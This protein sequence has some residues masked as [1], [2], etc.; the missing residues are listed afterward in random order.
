M[1]ARP[2][3]VA[4]LV[5]VPPIDIATVLLAAMQRD[6]DPAS[7]TL[8][9]RLGNEHVTGVAQTERTGVIGPGVSRLVETL[10]RP[11]QCPPVGGIQRAIDILENASSLIITALLNI[12]DGVIAARV[13]AVLVGILRDDQRMA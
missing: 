9:A 8:L 10:H 3:S 13:E 11:T 5:D 1:G 4:G 6:M 12:R 7:R 2:A